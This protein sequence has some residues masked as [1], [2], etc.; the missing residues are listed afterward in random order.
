MIKYNK[1]GKLEPAC[2]SDDGRLKPSI[3]DGYNYPESKRAFEEVV[4]TLAMNQ[5]VHELYRETLKYSV[6]ENL[7]FVVICND[8]RL[9]KNETAIFSLSREYYDR[10]VNAC[11][12]LLHKFKTSWK[13]LTEVEKYILKSLYFDDEKLTDEDLIENLL[14]NRNKLNSC[15]KSA[16]VKMDTQLNVSDPGIKG[17][18]K[19]P[20]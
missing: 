6:D 13:K 2:L 11:E 1:E 4:D 16:Y 20:L 19:L 15:K 9:D 7:N 10:N 18:L 5:M 3:L 17:N 8:P 12:E 14:S